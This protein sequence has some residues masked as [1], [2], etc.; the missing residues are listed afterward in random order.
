[1]VAPSDVGN[2]SITFAL[3]VEEGDLVSWFCL[4]D[5]LCV[6]VCLTKNCCLFCLLFCFTKRTFGIIVFLGSRPFFFFFFFFWGGVLQASE[7][8]PKYQQGVL[9]T[10]NRP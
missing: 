3:D 5:V 4:F 6:F 2:R 1:M 9:L 7:A 10:T 8:N